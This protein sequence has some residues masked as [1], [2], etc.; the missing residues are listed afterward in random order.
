MSKRF[1][2]LILA[3]ASLALAVTPALCGFDF[4][5]LE[6]SITEHT[7]DNGLKI[8]IMER[9]DAPV[10]SFITW[11][12]V[13]GVDDPK[14]YTGLAHMFEHMAFKGT[15]TLG[16]KDINKELEL[17]AAEDEVFLALRAERKKGRLADSTRIDSLTKAYD[18]ALAASYELVDP[19]A[20]SRAVEQE[21]GVGLNAGTAKDFT[22]YTASFPANR[23]ELWMALESE[24][25]LNPVLREMYK[26][27]DV[28]TEERRQVLEASPFGRLLDALTSAA[29]V[30]HPYGISVI[31]HMSD[32]LNYTREAAQAYYEKYYS[33]ANLTV[34]IVGDVK[35]K[36]VIKLAEQYWGRIPRRPVPDRIAT[37]EPEQ[38]GE[39][40]VILEDPAQPLY[41]VAWHIPEGTHPDFPAINALT[42]H[43]GWGRTSLLYKNL[44]KEK[45]IAIQSG[46]FAGYPGAKYPCLALVYAIP[47]AEHSNEE[48]EEQVFAEVKRLQDELI[49]ESEL[50]KIK[51]RSKAQ[52]IFGLSSNTGLAMELAASQTYY[53]DWRELFHELDRINAVTAEDIQ[54]VARTYFTKLNRTVAM[55]NTINNEESGE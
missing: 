54:R 10:A 25:F 6:E 55:I 33:P 8:I 18:A 31:G 2:W 26:E 4:S 29:F 52:F 21:G 12:N 38:K 49:S 20:F 19:N 50:E 30:A 47:A 34:A 32:I 37:I 42:Q 27:R 24:R 35:P 5:R 44:V 39:R 41:T 53:G 51:A 13:G 40:R 28:I 14:E 16:T 23:L 48:C 7:L 15:M 11:A 3:S 45:K 43:L 36:D 1:A 22:M 46:A 9:H 17:I